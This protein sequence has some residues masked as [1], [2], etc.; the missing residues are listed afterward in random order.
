MVLPR[1][2]VA[3]HWMTLATSLSLKYIPAGRRR[4]R[5]RLIERSQFKIFAAL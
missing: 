2:K 1:M 3:G 5:S 4:N